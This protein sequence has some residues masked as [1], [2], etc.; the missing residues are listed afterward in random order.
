MTAASGAAA[1]FAA[2]ADVRRGVPTATC[3]G[4]RARAE[5]GQ[6]LTAPPLI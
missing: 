3:E 2:G 5:Q 6:N 1:A 4:Q